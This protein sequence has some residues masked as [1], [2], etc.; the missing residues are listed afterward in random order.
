MREGIAVHLSIDKGTNSGNL[1]R[2]AQARDG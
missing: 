2:P 1:R